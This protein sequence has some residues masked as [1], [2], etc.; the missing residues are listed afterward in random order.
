[1][2]RELAS[3]LRY[4]VSSFPAVT[5]GPLHY[6]YLGKE[7]ITGL[8]Y[9]FWGKYSYLLKQK[10]GYNDGLITSHHV[11]IPNPDVTIY[12]DASLTG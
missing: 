4:I 1:M 9:K 2:L 12:T 6:R 3:I 10:L 7:E 11:S 5:S 8:K